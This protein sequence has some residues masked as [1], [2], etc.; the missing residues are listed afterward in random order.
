MSE[1]TPGNT[2]NLNGISYN[3][4]TPI[5]QAVSDLIKAIEIEGRA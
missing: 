3:D 5:A 4:G 1:Q 2:Y